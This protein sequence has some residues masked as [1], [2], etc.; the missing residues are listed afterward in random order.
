MKGTWA[1]AAATA[2]AIAMYSVPGEWIEAARPLRL[3][4]VTSIGACV[5]MLFGRLGRREPIF[6]DGFRG[7][8]LI[9]FVAICFASISWSV[10]PEASNAEAFELFKLLAIY[11]TM[12]NVITTPRRL[13]IFCSA[14]ALSSIV[15]SIGVIQ[16][17][18]TGLDL[19]EGYR[20][21]WLG[22]YADPN[23][24][25]MNIGLVIPISVAFIARKQTSWLMRGLYALAC[26]LGLTAI[27]LSHSRGGFLGLCL[28]IA[29][30]AFREQ[31]R[32]QALVV[33]SLV[34][35]GLVVFAPQSFWSR[36]ETLAQ[37][38]DDASAMGRVYA[39]NVASKI[40]IDRPLLGVGIG[41]FR[42]AWPLYAPA[43][44]HK[45][46]V[47][48]N[49]YLDVLGET[50]Y[51]GFFFFLMFTGSAAGGA[52]EA[53]KDSEVGWLSRALSGA[54]AGYVLC[55]CFSGYVPSPHFYVLMGLGACCQRI[56]ALRA[57]ETANE[58]AAEPAS[59]DPAVP[60]V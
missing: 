18:K 8:S 29:M 47:A 37:F 6:F 12:V 15:T 42:Y 17:W 52:F 60:V 3:A 9:A 49:V 39:W 32:L 38:H 35:L 24:M 23:H 4:L 2:F 11:L 7:W 16:W 34:M 50:G 27:V 58:P 13:M 22:V 48:H 31:R 21:R 51:L 20:A 56:V 28:A 25:A 36:N 45:A 57:K 5:F 59:A 46:Y 19:V 54:I 14:M 40:N 33:G 30:W 26:V 55:D 41:G 44:S 43:E 1:F 10:F 53:S